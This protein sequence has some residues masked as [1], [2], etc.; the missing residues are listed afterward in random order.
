MN[1]TV[2]I[3][4]QVSDLIDRVNELVDDGWKVSGGVAL[5]HDAHFCQ[6]MTKPVQYLQG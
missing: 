2:V 6:A 3:E 5:T 1:Y 4:Q